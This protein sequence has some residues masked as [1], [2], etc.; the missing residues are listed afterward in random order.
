MMQWLPLHLVGPEDA[1][2]IIHT[3]QEV[4]PYT[5][6]W[7]SFLTR[8]VLLVGSKTPHTLD[9]KRFERLMQVPE[10]ETAAR[11]IGVFSFL[12]LADFFLTGGEALKSYLRN[13]P[14]ITDDRPILEHSPVT[15]VPP[16]IWQTDESFLNLLR[17]RVQ[18]SPPLTGVTR[19]EGIKLQ[20]DL[21]LR[22]AQRLAVFSRRYHG[23]GEAAFANGNFL[24]GLEQVRNY[25]ES[26]G[27]TPV[28]LAGARWNG[29]R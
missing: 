10:L 24:G 4:F 9:R 11:Q 14:V 20:Q 7:N 17:H 15:L 28:S 29:I 13:A 8:I 26:A 18:S 3:F 21:D 25:L 5:S 2:A 22:T 1:R 12:D 19:E 6:A 27:E 23:P 16:L